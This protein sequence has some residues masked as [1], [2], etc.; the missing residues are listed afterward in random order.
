MLRAVLFDFNGV[1]V[2][3]EPLHGRLFQRVLAQEGVELSLADYY[4]RYL[5]LDDRGCFAAVLAAAGREVPPEGLARLIARKAS[6]YQEAVHRDGY[7][8]FP[9]VARVVA[10]A[11]AA[12]LVLGI[13]SGAL[14]AEIDGALA[15]AGLGA[16][17]RVVVAADDVERGKPDPEGYRVALERLNEEPPL[18]ARLIHPHEVVA[19]EDSP[20]GLA[21]ARSA[22][23]GTVA[24]A[25]S[26][27]ATELGQAAAVLPTIASLEIG[28][29]VRRF[30]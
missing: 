17:F 10:E 8:F 1:L 13:V 30:S 26:Y 4:A 6:Y 11:R 24:V 23:L 22:G 2:D 5:G 28:E 16:Q 18:P 19:V 20:A 12:G 14:A 25:T 27:P 3:D 9:G 7:P 29:L 21:A 15:Q